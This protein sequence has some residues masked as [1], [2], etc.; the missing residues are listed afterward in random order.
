MWHGQRTL[1]NHGR[2]SSPRYRRQRHLLIQY[3]SYSLI[4]L[5]IR[6]VEVVLGGTTVRIDG[7]LGQ[8]MARSS[9]LC[10]INKFLVSN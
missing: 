1:V 3:S 10:G 5:I 7:E 8:S 4:V 9:K 2:V 6:L